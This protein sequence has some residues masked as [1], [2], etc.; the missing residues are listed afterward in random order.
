MV[1]KLFKFNNYGAESVTSKHHRIKEINSQCV[2]VA[3][4][5]KN[6]ASATAGQQ[7]HWVITHHMSKTC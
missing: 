6:I 2:Y 3:K 4:D 1:C 5:R 7:Q